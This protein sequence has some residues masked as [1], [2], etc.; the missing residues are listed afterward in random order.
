MPRGAGV[1]EAAVSVPGRAPAL[2]RVQA[3]DGEPVREPGPV[4][5]PGLEPG[6]VPAQGRAQEL[7]QAL[8]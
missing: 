4:P 3:R 7:V 2:V 1:S 5:G 8:V 6:L